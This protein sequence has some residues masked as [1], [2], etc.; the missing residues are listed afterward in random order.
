MGGQSINVIKILEEVDSSMTLEGFKN[1]LEE[2][3]VGVVGMTRVPEGELK[4]LTEYLS[5][6]YNLNW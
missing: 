2:V 4:D 1:S 3:T 5:S 6:A